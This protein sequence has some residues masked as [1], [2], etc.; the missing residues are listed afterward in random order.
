[1]YRK[2]LT[3]QQWLLLLLL[4]L[5]AL[6]SV[7]LA[8]LTRKSV[9]KPG[10]DMAAAAAMQMQRCMDAVRAEKL[11]RGI[12]IPAV[13]R[14]ETGLLGEAYNFTTTT[15]GD[16]AAKRTTCDPNMAGLMVFMLEE[17]GLQPGDTLGCCFSGSFPALNIAVLT[18]C[19][20]MGVTPVY[21][22]SCGASTW[23]ANNPELSF[24]EMA[25]L[26]YRQGLISTA[27]A[28]ITAGGGDDVGQVA[29]SEAFAEIRSRAFG[30]GY[31]T[32]TEPDLKKNVTYKKSLLDSFCIDAFISVGGSISAMGTNMVT[33]LIGQGIIRENISVI[34]DGSGLIEYYLKEGMPVL[35][36]LNIKQLCA[37]YGIPF[38][39]QQQEAVGSGSVYMKSVYGQW[40][41]WLGLAAELLVLVFYYRK[42][43]FFFLRK[44]HFYVDLCKKA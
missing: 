9:Q 16:L 39:P 14:F 3:R 24:P 34:N 25:D 28:L 40:A 44:Q 29:D 26:L 22:A 43:I 38:D 42:T 36:L 7:S 23:G 27:P 10:Y 33:D 21:L 37:D 32:L 1:M 41:L 12:E 19:D 20:A 2:T 5:I 30:L 4:L 8:V 35:L 11:A 31:P 18:A 6:L 13:D 15:L 17:A